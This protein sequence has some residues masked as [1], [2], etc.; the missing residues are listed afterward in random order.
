MSA[1]SELGKAE[2]HRPIASERTATSER[3]SERSYNGT[4][5]GSEGSYRQRKSHYLQSRIGCDRK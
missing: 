1:G 2:H 5:V 3:K 4:G